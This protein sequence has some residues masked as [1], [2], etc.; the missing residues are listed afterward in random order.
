M[1]TFAAATPLAP[2]LGSYS[3]T[4]FIITVQSV[5]H[6]LL[7][8][9]TPLAPLLGSY[10]V[11][12]FIITVQSVNHI[13]LYCATPLAPLLGSYSVT[14]FIITVQ[15]VNHIVLYYF[16]ECRVVIPIFHSVVEVGTPNSTIVMWIVHRR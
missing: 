2:L 8:C 6:I 16:L 14:R 9:A 3:V 15:S 12:R 4:R 1:K 7:Y 13:L 11:T 5:N 10:S